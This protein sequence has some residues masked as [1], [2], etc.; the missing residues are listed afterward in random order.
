LEIAY[1]ERLYRGLVLVKWLLAAPHYLVL[2]LLLGIG[3]DAAGPAGALNSD[4]DRA[5]FWGLIQILV[6]VAAVVVLFRGRYPRRL[7]DLVIGLDR[8]VLR[9]VAYVALMTDDYPPFHLDQGGSEPHLADTHPPAPRATP[10]ESGPGA[11]GAR[12]SGWSGGRVAAVAVGAVLGLAALGLLTAGG[13]GLAVHQAARHDGYLSTPTRP[14]QTSGYALT[15]G[16]VD[17]G[18]VDVKASWADVLGTVRVRATSN[19]PAKPVFIGIARTADVNAYLGG[20]AY[21]TVRPDG[22]AGAGSCSGVGGRSG[23]RDGGVGAEGRV[24]HR[25]HAGDGVDEGVDLG[26]EPSDDGGEGDLAVLDMYPS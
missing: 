19:D 9:V 26:M 24:P 5:P 18:P 10:V 1:P 3:G 15:S 4:G 8:W 6:V 17:L 2:A 7:Y 14:L 20:V 13:V 16:K 23:S 21:S 22:E 25:D 12:A 11:E